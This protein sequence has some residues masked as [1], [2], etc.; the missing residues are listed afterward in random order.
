MTLWKTYGPFRVVWLTSRLLVLA[1]RSIVCVPLGELTLLP[2]V[3]G[4]EIVVP[5][6]VTALH[7]VLFRQRLLCA[8]LRIVS[9]VTLVLLVTSVMAMLP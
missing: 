3:I 4:T 5:T 8:W 7:L 9:V 1:A 6:V 2:V